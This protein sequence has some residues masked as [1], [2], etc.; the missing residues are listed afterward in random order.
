M[1]DSLIPFNAGA[2]QLADQL[3]KSSLIPTAL[4]G[5]PAD[6]LVILMKGQELGLSPIQ[7]LSEVSVIEGKPSSSAALK[8]ALCVRR[9][10][11]CEYFRMTESTATKATYETKRAGNEPVSLS[12]T[13]EQAKTA[14]LTGKQNWQRHP[15]AMLRARCSSALATAVYPDLVQGLMTFDEADEIP[16][17]RINGQSERDITPPAP[18]AASRTEEVKAKLKE[19]LAA[20]PA[21]IT[22]SV[23]PTPEELAMPYERIKALGLKY[24]KSGDAMKSI[25]KGATNGKTSKSALTDA[26]VDAVEAALK[27]LSAAQAKQEV[28]QSQADL[29]QPDIF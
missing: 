14:G 13:I 20:L 22:V 2:M 9:P 12:W 28:P 1:S 17:S 5:K 3:A 15:D 11:I 19:Q 24:G 26:D 27:V 4:R 7:S 18:L 6:V 21:T 8:V 29:L 23:E 25:V 16:G 10:D